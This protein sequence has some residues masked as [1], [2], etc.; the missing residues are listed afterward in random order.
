MWLII[1]CS[2]TRTLGWVGWGCNQ[3]KGRPYRGVMLGHRQRRATEHFRHGHDVSRRLSLSFRDLCRPSY[4]HSSLTVH[5]HLSLDQHGVQRG[6]TSYIKF[7]DIPNTKANAII[8]CSANSCCFCCVSSNEIRPVK[9]CG[10]PPKR[11][12]TVAFCPM[13]LE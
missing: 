10:W 9:H 2:G 5:F 7:L 11:F 4:P 6:C 8:S 12:L 1:L 13:N 3:D